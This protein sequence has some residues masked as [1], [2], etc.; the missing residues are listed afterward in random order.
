MERLTGYVRLLAF[1]LTAHCKY[2]TLL[3]S[4]RMSGQHEM[5]YLATISHMIRLQFALLTC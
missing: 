4:V 2:Y 5:H 1:I 3:C